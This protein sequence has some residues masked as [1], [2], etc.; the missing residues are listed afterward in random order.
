MVTPPRTPQNTFDTRTSTIP[1]HTWHSLQL[2]TLD[3]VFNWSL[4]TTPPRTKTHLPSSSTGLCIKNDNLQCH[5]VYLAHLFCTAPPGTR[6]KIK[7]NTIFGDSLGRTPSR[8]PKKT[9]KQLYLETLWGEPHP[10]NQK[11]KEP[12]KNKKQY[13]ETLGWTPYPQDLWNMCFFVFFPELFGFSYFQNLGWT[14][15]SRRQHMKS[16]SVAFCCFRA[17][18]GWPLYFRL[19]LIMPIIA[20]P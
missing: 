16:V 4:H 20:R 11:R 2:V 3:T 8:K 5:T 19:Q 9:K 13:L 10:E 6:K 14:H 18:I 17:G 12:W 7:K 1:K 15:R